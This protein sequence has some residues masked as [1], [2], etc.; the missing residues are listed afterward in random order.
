MQV[1]AAADAS[2]GRLAP[3]YL[4]APQVL[5]VKD[6]TRASFLKRD[7]NVLCGAFGDARRYPMIGPKRP[8]R[9]KPVEP[10][11]NAARGRT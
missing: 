11:R 5:A 1:L 2:A 4:N 8:C 6:R 7:G 3:A 10:E 9:E